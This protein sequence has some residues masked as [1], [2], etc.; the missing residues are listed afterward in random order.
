[1]DYSDD[2][3]ASDQGAAGPGDP[4]GAEHAAGA[5]PE[6][7]GIAPRAPPEAAEVKD[8]PRTNLPEVAIKPECLGAIVP[9]P[10]VTGGRSGK[11]PLPE[12]RPSLVPE[13]FDTY[14]VDDKAFSKGT[15]YYLSKC[16]N[17]FLS[18]LSF[19][20]CSPEDPRLLAAIFV[21]GLHKGALAVPCLDIKY[22]WTHAIVT[23]IKVF[24]EWQIQVSMVNINKQH[25]SLLT[26]V[27]S[28]G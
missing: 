20:N 18:M 15:C 21:Q 22:T 6:P 10:K 24:C 16:L 1:M 3:G 9:E 17:R 2:D 11:W 5:G 13:A 19:G 7:K 27:V 23:V 25:A 12:A 14:L 28:K 8:D 4:V 26:A